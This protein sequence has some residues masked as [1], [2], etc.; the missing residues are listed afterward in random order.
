[1]LVFCCVS[2]HQGRVS[3]IV[4]SLLSQ[5]V[6]ST[7]YDKSVSWMCTQSGSMLG[8]HYFGSWVSCLQYPLVSAH[9]THILGL[10]NVLYLLYLAFLVYFVFSL[11]SV[12]MWYLSALWA[13]SSVSFPNCM[14]RYDDDT[15]HAFVGDYSGQ[16]TLLKLERQ[17]YSTITTLKGHEGKIHLN[18]SIH[19]HCPL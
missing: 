5:W 15:Q 18:M 3:D 4:F 7:G 19:T 10:R 17:S 13:S 1:M 14:F 2:A 16:I 6:V 12:C 11:Q 8:C 9:T